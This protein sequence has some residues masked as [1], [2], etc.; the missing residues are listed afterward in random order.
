MTCSLIVSNNVTIQNPPAGLRDTI[1]RRLTLEN[2]KYLENE[3][4]GRW[5][6]DTPQYLECYGWTKDGLTLPRGFIRQLIGICRGQGIRYELIDRRRTLPEVSFTFSGTL[7]PFQDQAVKDVLARDFGTLSAPTGSGKT[8]MGLSV[9]AQRRQPALVVCHTGEL[10]HQWADRIGTFLS[11]PK[12]EIGI[13]GNGKRTVGEKITV[14]L[15]QS[16]YKCAAEVAPH[17]G[18]VVLDECHRAPSR[19]FTEAVSAFDSR[20]MLGLSA[21]PWRRDGLSRLIFWYVGDVVHKIESEALQ[22]TGDIL[23]ADVIQRETTFRTSFDPSEEYSQMLSELTEDRARNALIADDVVRQAGNGGGICLILSDRKAHCETLARMIERQGIP[24]E[25]LTGDTA[26]GKR[27]EIVE[28]LNAGA[29][30]VLV[31]TGQLIGEGFDCKALSTLFLATPIKFSGRLI[32][33]LGR[34]LRPAPGKDQAKV[35][36]YVDVRIGVLRAAANARSRVY[37]N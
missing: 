9:I 2:P 18:F 22:D 32:Q 11:I 34:V 12:N 26:N 37:G 10:L 29:V 7:K 33:Y 16:L 14:A 25:I 36:D 15:V 24:A 28:R 19:T 23:R 17:V 3:Q 4:Q 27:Q 30:K 1:E 21:T 6:G 35:F 5:N 13:I 31:A 20:Y 8:V